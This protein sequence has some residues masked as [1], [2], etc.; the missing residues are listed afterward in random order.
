MAILN[1]TYL[2]SRENKE[3][4]EKQGY[5]IV[6]NHNLVELYQTDRDKLAT[7]EDYE[8][9]ARKICG[10]IVTEGVD[11]I[12]FDIKN[13]LLNQ[14]IM[15][16]LAYLGISYYLPIIHRYKVKGLVEV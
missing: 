2:I 5:E 1:L 10:H 16:E 6:T 13:P 12:V 8:K 11:G 3:N 9:L 14:I 7:L 4:L 15:R